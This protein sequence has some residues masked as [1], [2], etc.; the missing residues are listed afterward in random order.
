MNIF[1]TLLLCSDWLNAVAVVHSTFLII[2]VTTSLLKKKNKLP[3]T[4]F[5]YFLS[6]VGFLQDD[7][8]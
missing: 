6:G 7:K 4:V 2:M 1:I 3:V 5:Q 8:H